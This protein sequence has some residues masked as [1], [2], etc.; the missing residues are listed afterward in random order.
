MLV[1]DP[2][3]HEHVALFNPRLDSWQTHFRWEGVWVMGLTPTGR[4][5]FAALNMNR[6]LALAIREEETYIA[7]DTLLGDM[8]RY[9]TAQLLRLSSVAVS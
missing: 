8:V 9:P 6:P 4:A 5:T 3:T 7:A 2:Q 1:P